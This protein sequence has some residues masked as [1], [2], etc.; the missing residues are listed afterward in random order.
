MA[1]QEIEIHPLESE[2]SETPVTKAKSLYGEP[3]K[4]TIAWDRKYGK[5]TA[6]GLLRKKPNPNTPPK[7]ESEE[8]DESDALH[9]I[10]GE[11]NA[12]KGLYPRAANLI[13]HHVGIILSKDKNKITKAHTH[14]KS[15]AIHDYEIEAALKRA[16]KAVSES[17]EIDEASEWESRHVEFTKAGAAATPEHISKVQAQLK[18]LSSKATALSKRGVISQI[19]N[20][21]LARAAHGADIYH[22]SLDK[23]K[24]AKHGSAARK[25][26]GQHITYAKSLI[27]RHKDL[28]ESEEID[29]MDFGSIGKTLSKYGKGVPKDDPKKVSRSTVHTDYTMTGH[30][31][32]KSSTGR[33]YTKVLSDY[34]DDAPKAAKA[35]QAPD[36]VEAPKRG[37]GRPAGALNKNGSGVTGKGW[38]AESKAAFKAKLA[39]KK[40]EKAAAK[41]ESEFVEEDWAEI[42][43]GQSLDAI[44]EFM[45]DE[46][47]QSLDE[48]SKAT[49]GSY[50]KKAAANRGENALKHRALY[51]KSPSHNDTKVHRDTYNRERGLKKA[52]DK[53][54]ITSGRDR[55]AVHRLTY[56]D[57]DPKQKERD[58][59]RIDRLT[60]ESAELAESTEDLNIQRY[61]AML[62]KNLIKE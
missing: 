62:G 47:Y 24:Q 12:A 60:K 2:I 26:L 31:E 41:N 45:M 50:I 11:L 55:M 6:K 15:I 51:A 10:A 43:E 53:I 29:E 20:G 42:T 48:L 35:T 17:T 21:D 52:S 59:K 14:M 18:K 58:L 4:G 16:H 1:K 30:K 5:Y 49:L 7:N 13:D 54:G 22:K 39:A 36:Q 40:A 57:Q 61:A 8:I 46:E 9:K 23:N 28:V 37:R 19:S 27:A 3:P 32:K 33:V 25:E 44:V 34:D 38:S 56:P